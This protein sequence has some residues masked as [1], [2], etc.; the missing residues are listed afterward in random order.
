[1]TVESRSQGAPPF[2]GITI[3]VDEENEAMMVD[4]ESTGPRTTTPTDNLVEPIQADASGIYK[5]KKAMVSALKFTPYAFRALFE[6]ED[7][8]DKVALEVKH[9]SAVAFEDGKGRG[10]AEW[11]QR[12][13]GRT[14]EEFAR[15]S[16]EIGLEQGEARANAAW[17]DRLHSEH[18]DADMTR[19]ILSMPIVVA[20]IARC[21]CCQT[22]SCCQ[23]TSGALSTR[24][25]DR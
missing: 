12:L 16:F 10:N 19:T 22:R 2:R 6:R 17:L 20:A 23:R 18:L 11:Q 9:S 7:V 4:N 8:S 15:Q 13:G 3:P 1:M 25:L 24:R 5:I 14:L 21:R